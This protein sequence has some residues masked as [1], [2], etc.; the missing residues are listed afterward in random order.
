MLEDVIKRLQ[1][2]GFSVTENDNWILNFCVDKVENHIKNNCNVSEVPQGLHEVAVDLICGEYLQGKFN[3]GQLGDYTQAISK[4][5]EGDTDITF[6][7]GTSEVELLK[8][9]INTLCSREIDFAAYR[10]FKW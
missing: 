3:A 8:T 10:R 5:K 1:G 4:I 6:V 7:S 2:L 9:L